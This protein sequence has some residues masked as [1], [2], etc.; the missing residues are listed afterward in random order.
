MSTASPAASALLAVRSP[1]LLDALAAPLRDAGWTAVAAGQ[2]VGDRAA[3]AA[4]CPGLEFCRANLQTPQ[5][6]DE[7]VAAAT[8][9]G[10]QL[11]LLLCEVPPSGLA[12]EALLHVDAPTADALIE[13][14]MRTP[15]FLTQTLA[16]R[17]AA[18]AGAAAPWQR[19][20]LY[21]AP[22]SATWGPPPHR[23]PELNST[24][25]TVLTRLWALRLA[26][27]H[28]AVYELRGP[29]ETSSDGWARLGRLAFELGTGGLS[30]ATG[31]VFTAGR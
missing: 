7:A 22:E 9:D 1:Q 23:D 11:A 12:D 13:S 20:V 29:D 27:L 17:W 25:A 4:S 26:E 30:Y 6:R 14:G 21:L 31:N 10:R 3:A 16:R 24:A 5:G 18:D 19:R 28:A 8:R 15:F 2:G